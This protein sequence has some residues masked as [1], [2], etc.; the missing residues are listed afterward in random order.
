MTV[1]LFCGD[2][3][4]VMPGLH[5]PFDMIL[6]DLPYGTT[7]CKWDAV[8]PFKLLWAEYKRLIKACGAV[9]LFGNQPFSSALV[10]SNIEQFRHSWV[11][12]KDKSAGFFS[13]PYMP[14]RLC[15]TVSVFSHGK[16]GHNSIYRCTYNPQMTEG[17]E[18]PE[19]KI[20]RKS[21]GQALPKIHDR[22]ESSWKGYANANTTHNGVLRY[23]VDWVYYPSV[24]R[25]AR[26][27]P[28]Q[29]PVDLLEYLIRT[30]TN[31]GE[32]VL[33]NVMGSGS[34]GV[35]CVNTGRNFVGI[36]QD[37]GYFEIAKQRI[38]VAQSE[39]VQA[40]MKV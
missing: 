13:A 18:Y 26:V 22:P 28:T 37:M 4:D 8:I 1:E 14:L 30:Y 34:T 6:A 20:S 27:H 24:C 25:N 29:K 32:T 33:D 23:P 38:E 19:N 21:K 15:E 31:E 36:E 35:A 40:R 12:I 10:V 2:C 5:G 7:D 39:M 3:L 16:F 9:A 11:W 17:K